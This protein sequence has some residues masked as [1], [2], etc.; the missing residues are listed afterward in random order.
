MGQE[1]VITQHGSEFNQVSFKGGMNMLDDD[2][3]LD[4]SQYR[5][6]F[7]LTNR[8]DKLSPVLGSVE[9]TS[10]PA[11]IIQE[12]VTF[13][14]YLV[15]FISG[16]AYY[17]LYS[18]Q[19]WTLISGFTMN[20]AATR[21]WTCAV[22]V[23]LTNYVRFATNSNTVVSGSGL[24]SVYFPSVNNGVQ[25]MIIAGAAGGN[26]PGLLVQ[27]N[28]NQP[29]FIYLDSNGVPAARK[30]QGFSDWAI[31]FTD[32]TNTVVG[33]AGGPQDKT[34]DLREYV[35]IG[36]SMCWSNGILFIVSS[37]TNSIY[38]SVS[39]RP[40][41]FMVNVTNALVTN[42]SNFKGKNAF[43]QFGGGDATT[44]NYSVGVGGITAIRPL[45]TGGIL[46]CASNANF[47]V[48]LNQTQNAPTVFGEYTFNRQFLFNA[49]CVGDRAILD[50]VGDTRFVELTGIRSFNAV[51][52][53]ENE[54]RNSPFS[55][56]VQGIFGPDENPLTQSAET[57]AAILYNNY[58]LYAVN[59]VLGYAIGKYDTINDCWTSFD[60]QQT[61]GV[62]IKQFAKIELDVLR[63]YAITVD[64]RLFV[65]YAGPKKTTPY[66]R[67]LG[68]CSSIL[69]AGNPVKMA[70]PK[71][72]IKMQK[73]RA[74]IGGI[75]QDETVT[76]TPYCN[77][78]LTMMGSLQKTIVYE[79]SANPAVDPLA[80]S[81]VDTQ[82]NN[83]LWATPDVNTGWKYFLTFTWSNGDLIQYST[84]MD[85]VTP[86]NPE[87][88]QSS[89]I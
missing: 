87:F 49:T 78:R 51:K 80:L 35:P 60:M 52:Q 11:G 85:E 86:M 43:W 88:S 26:L 63:L 48:T 82:L 39:G 89:T 3:R 66:V 12:F 15:A 57:S 59:T 75:T 4:N 71:V 44:T 33:T 2:T 73:V 77:N 47:A 54:G 38:R 72:E 62:A 76:M 13:G 74:V 1:Q 46:V 55:L 5:I 32:A 17:K 29:F 56:T 10:V 69:W 22:P 9:D 19:V 37:D 61:N 67:T 83:L 41:D 81:D 53:Y 45:S 50:T 20:P 7:D 23:S 31:G 28:I 79:P 68:I 8:Y 16:K 36:N 18:E 25:Q 58:E 64:N 84:E 65:L 24:S 30:T 14:K 40:L 6:G 27:D 70:H 42:P 21:Y 34:L